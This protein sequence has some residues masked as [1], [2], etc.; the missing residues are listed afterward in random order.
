MLLSGSHVE[1]NA[2]AA[3]ILLL[4][5]AEQVSLLQVL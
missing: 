5:S 1:V 3:H 4:A 2:T